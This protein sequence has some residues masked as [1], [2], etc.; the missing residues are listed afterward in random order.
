MGTALNLETVLFFPSLRM[1][2]FPISLCLV[3]PFPSMSY[4]FQLARLSP[5]WSA[6][7][8]GHF[9]SC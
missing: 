3:L 2:H 1:E 8:L 6:L 7:F 5:L 4:S 9:Q